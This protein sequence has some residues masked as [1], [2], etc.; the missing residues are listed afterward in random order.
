MVLRLAC[1]F[2]R[3]EANVS[4]PFIQVVR[5]S[6]AKIA[7]LLVLAVQCL[8]DKIVRSLWRQGTDA[9]YLVASLDNQ[10]TTGRTFGRT[11]FSPSNTNERAKAKSSA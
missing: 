11:A 10:T 9:K 1:I 7:K 5:Q 4:N 6:H 8:L 3:S 2:R